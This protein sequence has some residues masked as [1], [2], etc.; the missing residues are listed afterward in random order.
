M[1]HAGPEALDA[2]EPILREVRKLAGLKEKKRGTF[3][4]GSS[5]MLHFHEDPAGMFADLKLR[6]EFVR[7]R[8][9]TKAEIAAMLR[10]ARREISSSA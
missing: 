4:R 2:I 9:S 1:K 10:E 8:V 5:A 6:G 7:F 3:Y